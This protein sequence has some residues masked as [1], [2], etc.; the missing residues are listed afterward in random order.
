T[1]AT[2]FALLAR[3]PP[4]AEIIRRL[5]EAYQPLRIYLFGSKARGDEGPDSDYD[6]L[7]V[8]PD[9]ASSERRDSRLAYEALWGTGTAADVLVCTNSYFE[10]RRHLRASLPGTVLREGKQLHAA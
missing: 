6:L 4:L 10:A 3:D 8:V 2:D 1:G 5:I 9:D 7:V